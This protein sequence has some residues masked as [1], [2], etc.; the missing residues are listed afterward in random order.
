MMPKPAIPNDKQRGMA[1]TAMAATFNR[2]GRFCLRAGIRI[3]ITISGIGV[4][5]TR[6]AGCPPREYCLMKT[7]ISTERSI[8]WA[9]AKY[10]EDRKDN[11]EDLRVIC[12]VV[13]AMMAKFT[14]DLGRVVSQKIWPI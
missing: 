9:I 2:I 4:I 1:A 6:S 13:Q 7:A 12:G 5:S 3:S 8:Q 14:D 10:S 11:E